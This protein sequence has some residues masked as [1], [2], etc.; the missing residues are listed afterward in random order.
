LA[1]DIIVA[2]GWAPLT[3]GLFWKKANKSAAISSLLVGFALKLI[4]FF[5]GDIIFG[6]KVSIVGFGTFVPL[7]ASVGV[8]IIVAMVTQ[9]KD[10]SRQ[11]V[12]ID[13]VP[14]YEDIFRGTDLNMYYQKQ[15]RISSDRKI[16][17]RLITPEK[18]TKIPRQVKYAIVFFY[19]TLAIGWIILRITLGVDIPFYVVSSES[20][21]PNLNVHDLLVIKHISS[22]ADDTSFEN[23]K[24]GDIIVF[25]TPGL[26]TEGTHR[27]IVHR[28]V[29]VSL[30]MDGHRIIQT[31]GDAN[32]KSIPGLD[33]PIKESEYIGKVIYVI[34]HGGALRKI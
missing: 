20:M 19:V 29:N 34:P 21:V 27:T 33:Y 32:P 28:I 6:F 5:M 30:D 7:I 14:P 2:G 13:Y 4:I 12:I 23:L 18:E 9:K 1:F 11:Q 24:P 3:F 17:S 16:E 15:G 8:F 10:P 25:K 31:K 22:S 26:T